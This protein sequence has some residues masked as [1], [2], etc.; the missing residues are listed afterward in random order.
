MFTLSSRL[1]CKVMFPDVAIVFGNEWL[2]ARWAKALAG[3]S[4]FHFIYVD[5]F[6]SR[7]WAVKC[8]S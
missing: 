3:I 8:I 7:T 6:A 5:K 2:M 4:I 1:M